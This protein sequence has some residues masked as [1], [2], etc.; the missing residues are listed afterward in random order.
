MHPD[1]RVMYH[2]HAIARK[3]RY[4]YCKFVALAF[5]HD[6]VMPAAIA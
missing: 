5:R 4:R 3:A 6:R 2:D 1:S